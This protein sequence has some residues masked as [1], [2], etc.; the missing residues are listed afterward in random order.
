MHINKI[1]GA[2]ARILYEAFEFMHKIQKTY[3]QTCIHVHVRNSYN[4]GP[5]VLSHV[6]KVI[7]YITEGKA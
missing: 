2:H 4:M 5:Y 7:S 1:Q 6:H 3:V